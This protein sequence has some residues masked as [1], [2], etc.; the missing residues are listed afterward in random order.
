VLDLVGP[1]CAE[2]HDVLL[3]AGLLEKALFTAAHFDHAEK[4]QWLVGRF[5]DFLQSHRADVATH[6]EALAGQS[7]RGLRKLGMREEIDSLLHL[8]AEAI[9]QDA[10]VE[11]LRTRPNWPAVLRTLLHVAAGWF[12]FGKDEEAL[13]FLREARSLLLRGTLSRQELVALTCRYI[14]TLG[15]APVDLAL[16]GID[17]LLTNLRGVFDSLSTNK[18]YSAAQLQVVEAIVLGVVTEDF[19]MGGE[20]RRWLDDDEYLVRRRIHHDLQGFLANAGH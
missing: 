12:Y 13:I 18:Y 16:Q 6:G 8:L 9:L 2:T 7:L 1:A 19:A 5:R 3:L 11:A 20:V 4:V 15:Q 10:D 14:Q 17:E